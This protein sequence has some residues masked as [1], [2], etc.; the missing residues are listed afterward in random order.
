MFIL[1]LSKNFL[2]LSFDKYAKADQKT[3]LIVTVRNVKLTK[4]WNKIA[5]SPEAIAKLV[6]SFLLFRKLIKTLIKMP[7][8]RIKPIMPVLPYQSHP[9]LPLPEQT[10]GFDSAVAFVRRWNNIPNNT[11]K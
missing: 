10:M 8:K 4:L 5:S 6:K 9:D 2:D 1:P 3:I 7:L 11:S